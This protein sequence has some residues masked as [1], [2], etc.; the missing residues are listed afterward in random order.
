MDSGGVDVLII[1][2]IKLEGEVKNNFVVLTRITMCHV[3]SDWEV[4]FQFLDLCLK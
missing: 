2:K 1:L 4:E 3:D